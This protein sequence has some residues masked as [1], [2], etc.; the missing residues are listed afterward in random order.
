MIFIKQ[1]R[2]TGNGYSI[3][4]PAVIV[5]DM[6]WTFGDSVVCYISAHDTVSLKKVTRETLEAI[7]NHDEPIIKMD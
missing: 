6:G 4:V 1:L 7:V 3:A 2:K 5:D